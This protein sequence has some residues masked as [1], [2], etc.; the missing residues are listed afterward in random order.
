MR[1]LLFINGTEANM[2]DPAPDTMDR[3]YAMAEEAIRR[4]AYVTCDALQPTA[5]ATQVRVRDDRVIRTDGPFAES[6]EIVGGF[7][8]VDCRDMDE[9]VELAAMIPAPKD[10]HIEVRSV[11]TIDGWDERIADIRAR[12]AGAPAR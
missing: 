4:G 6:K 12:L 2:Q 7:Y 5:G 11:L 1:F 10:G 9:A 3:H 8:M